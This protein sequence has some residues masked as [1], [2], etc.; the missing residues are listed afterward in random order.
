MA[1]ATTAPKKKKG[2]FLLGAFILL[3]VLSAIGFGL[4]KAGVI[5]IKPKAP[6]APTPDPSAEV[7][8]PVSHA[9]SPAAPPA[10]AP[11]PSSNIGKLAEAAFD[12]VKVYI[13][14]SWLAEDN[15]F[16]KGDYIGHVTKEYPNYYEVT[17][18]GGYRYAYKSGVTLK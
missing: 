9:K 17:T 5:K 6:D 14:T 15:H 8:T 3:L 7:K 4:Y 10:T 2:S 1:E 18:P 11:Q 12:G 16:K 13:T